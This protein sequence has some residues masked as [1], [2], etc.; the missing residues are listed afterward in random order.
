MAGNKNIGIMLIRPV[1]LGVISSIVVSLIGVMI[2]SKLQLKDKVGEVSIRT[3]L[4]A[5]IAVSS[6]L[7]SQ[8]AA[9]SGDKRTILTA[10]VTGF[11]VMAFMLVGGMLLDGP[12][13]N[14]G[15]TMI[16]LGVGVG[17]SCVL[18]MKQQG[19]G[20]RRNKRIR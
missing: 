5:L 10:M 17:I 8:I 15:Q 1:A 13:Q 11:V 19:K 2:L 6:L 4:L 20:R 3:G 9:R 7:G 14:V 16:A 18:C 12:F